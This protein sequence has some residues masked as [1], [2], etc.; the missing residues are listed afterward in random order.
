MVRRLAQ[1]ALTA[2]YARLPE[3]DA[4]ICKRNCYCCICKASSE[5]HQSWQKK[6]SLLHNPLKPRVASH[7]SLK[8]RILIASQ[9]MQ[10]TS[11]A[12]RSSSLPEDRWPCVLLEW[13]STVHAHIMTFFPQRYSM[14]HS[15]G[16]PSVEPSACLC[17]PAWDW[18]DPT[19]RAYTY[20]DILH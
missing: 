4:G 6:L 20:C 8:P 11:A 14:A 18:S 9:H 1:E 12:C 7:N 10:E 16:P 5:R 3:D 2:A 19:A 17:I 13:H 15:E